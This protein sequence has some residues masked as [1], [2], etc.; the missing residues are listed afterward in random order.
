M[1]Q[2]REAGDQATRGQADN[3]E[4]Q[5]EGTEE[6]LFKASDEAID[7]MKPAISDEESFK[8]LSSPV[9]DSSDKPSVIRA[10]TTLWFKIIGS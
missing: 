1:K 3:Q 5:T 7:L 10:I 2:L 6:D 9:K 4:E 8:K